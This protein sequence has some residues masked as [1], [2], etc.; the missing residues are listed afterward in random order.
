[1]S[2]KTPQDQ[3][4]FFLRP[5]QDKDAAAIA[6][7]GSHI[8]STTFGYSMPAPDLAHYLQEA[9]SISSIKNDISDPNI[10]LIVACNPQDEV[11]GFSQLRRGSF[12][13]CIAGKP[14]P[15]ELQRLYVNP[16]NHGQG[17]ARVLVDEIERLAREG[18]F[19]TMWLG[20]SVE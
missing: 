14:K 8:F 12:E 18:G 5:A 19:E 3:K 4:N 9:Y 15:I 10:D 2:E 6:S 11:I 17:I 20:Q 16:E 7:L 13:P 1:M